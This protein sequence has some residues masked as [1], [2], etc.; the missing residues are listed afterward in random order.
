MREVYGEFPYHNDGLH[1]DGGV[2]DDAI[3]QRCW[4]R[5]AAQLARWYA[6]PIEAVGRRFTAILYVEWQGVIDRSWN[7]EK[8]LVFSHI[9]LTKMLGICRSWEIRVR[10]TRRMDLWER[11]I[12]AGLV[13]DTEA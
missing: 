2:A 12:H 5:L 3:W 8:P 6:T 1:L 13:G 10:I 4:H 7:F 9:F 11:G